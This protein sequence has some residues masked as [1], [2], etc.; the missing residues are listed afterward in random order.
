MTDKATKSKAEL[1]EQFI[2]REL[3]WCAFNNRVLEEAM[4]PN[5][6]LLERFRIASIVSSNLDEFFM[7]RVSALK[8][9]KASG[10]VGV[11]PSGYS[12]AETLDE[13]CN[14]VHTMVKNLYDTIAFILPLARE[15]AISIESFNSLIPE[16]QER[17]KEIFENEIFPVLTPMAVD[18]VHP[19]PTLSNLSLNL[20]VV[21]APEHADDRPRLAIVPIPS[22]LPRLLQIPGEKTRFVMLEEVIRQFLDRLF[23]GQKI[24][25][26]A[27]FRITRDAA[28]E[29]DDEGSA[30][31]LESL[32]TEL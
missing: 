5:T 29:F 1:K 3:S 27:I 12:P 30:D 6:P 2:N 14:Q 16:Q 24:E 18:P 4:D 19:F 32:E 22:L 8:H 10:E 11:D 25:E 15:N 28:F 21:L 17:I 31:L 23:M 20:A 9:L 26:N 13:V 7:V